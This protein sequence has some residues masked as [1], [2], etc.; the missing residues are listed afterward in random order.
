MNIESLIKGRIAE[1][2][3]ELLLEESGYR[4]VRIG[5]EGLLVN[6]NREYTRKLNKSD[7]AGKITTAPSFAVFNN[8]SKIVILLKVKFR[9]MK[10]NGRNIAHGLGQLQEYWPEAILLVV[11]S[12]SPYFSVVDNKHNGNSINKIFP[13]IKKE[14]LV[15][16]GGLI[17]KF[18]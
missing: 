17:K 7:S 1:C 8:N 6:V 3:V 18:L 15:Y 4:V 16:F 13:L 11:T 10:G 2:I 12:N 5:R 9:G 14:S